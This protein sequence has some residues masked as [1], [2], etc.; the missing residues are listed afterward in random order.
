MYKDIILKYPETVQEVPVFPKNTL[1]LFI[2]DRCNLRC[3]G[4]FYRE[5]LGAEDMLYGDYVDYIWKYKEE[6]SKIILLGG[7]PTLHPNFFNMLDFNQSLSFKTTVYTNG[8]HLKGI[9]N[10]FKDNPSI[11]DNTTIRVGVHGFECSDKP[12]IKVQKI[13]DELKPYLPIHFVYM[14]ANYNVGELDAAVEYAKK[15]YNVTGVYLSSIRELDVT[16]DYWLDTPDTIPIPEYANI[17]QNFVNNYDFDVPLHISTRGLI[18]TENNDFKSINKCRFGN[19]MR[20]G[21]L[22]TSPFDISQQILSEELSFG[23]QECKRH[24]KCVLQKIILKRK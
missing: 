23:T 3:K 21:D 11:R 4:C 10:I 5:R 13:S 20:N 2:T 15:H 8:S 16:G 24:N 7:E 19:V 6:V 18:I 17:V 1:Q 9:A 14:L 12:L 22:I